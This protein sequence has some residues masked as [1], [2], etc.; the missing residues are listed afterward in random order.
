MVLL[1]VACVSLTTLA[2]GLFLG[3]SGDSAPRD[4][5]NVDAS[6]G[7]A[8]GSSN[9]ADAGGPSPSGRD[10][11]AG[12][13]PGST[14]EENP[15]G[16]PSGESDASVPP[17]EALPGGEIFTEDQVLDV[18]ITLSNEDRIELEEHGNL[19]QYVAG[20]VSI[21][22][23]GFT[24]FE[25]AE[26]GVRHKGN[27]SLHHCWEDDVRDYEDECAKLSYKLKFDEY[28]DTLRFNGLKRL[29]LHASSGDNT[30]LRELLAY[31]TFADFGIEA[32]R[33]AVA[34]VTVNDELAGLFF[35]VEE[36][37]GRYTQAHFPEGPNGNLYK[38]IWPVV[39]QTDE[40]FVAAL[41]TN[42]TTADV[43]DMRGFAAAIAGATAETFIA[44]LQPWLDIEELLRYVVV[45]RAMKN[46]DG[47][48]AFY[49]P[50][51]P[52]NFFWYHDDGEAGLFHLLPWDMDNTFWVTDPYMTPDEWDLGVPPVPDWN[53]APANCEPREVWEPGSGTTVAPPR[54]DKL[55]D[56][57]AQTQWERFVTLGN[58][59]RTNVLR[60]PRFRERLDRWQALL[61]PLI[62]EDPTLDADAIAS[63]QAGF[64]EILED[65]DQDFGAYLARGLQSEVLDPELDLRPEPTSEQLSEVGYAAGL[66][67]DRVNNFEFTDGVTGMVLPSAETLHDDYSFVE[68]TWNVEDPIAGSADARIDFEHVS[69]EGAYS[70]WVNL[71]LY[72]QNGI[73]DLTSYSQLV[74][75]LRADGPR[76]VRV[77]LGGAASQ[78][79]FGGVWDEFGTYFDVDD[80]PKQ[81]ILSLHDL[82]YPSWA[83]D[84]WQADQGWTGTDE[85]AL[86]RVLATF[87]ALIFVPGA[88]VDEDTGELL[89]ASD[90]G[91]LEIDNVYFR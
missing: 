43:A 81:V 41:E 48:M 57:L 12:E 49:D 74:M 37:D 27:Y 60:G 55:L 15:S 52:H 69:S 23:N 50:L 65:I 19:E 44:D 20:R 61:E 31:T 83:K 9:G 53:V 62:A 10:A 89:D 30:K 24:A 34:R 79:E 70:E 78:D 8:Q 80:E 47:I 33:I 66:Y 36:L 38:E 56:L 7:S 51:T 29:N 5:D 58:D 18:H 4:N 84:A 22:G 77:R 11:A 42:E 63:E 45:D 28:D 21:S 90:V 39:S 13:I 46:W 1:R 88:R 64:R 32:P 76:T 35:A 26:V 67:L 72:T 2:T 85:Q 25:G 86:E 54:C 87:F 17:P 40:E 3:C 75:T 91:F 73:E 16:A 14:A 6:H 59:F 68:A 82:E 71:F